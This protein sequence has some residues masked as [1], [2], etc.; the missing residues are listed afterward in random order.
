MS[1]EDSIYPRAAGV[2]PDF[3]MGDE[4]L[5]WCGWPS[6]FLMTRAMSRPGGVVDGSMLWE[7][8]PGS[9]PSGCCGP[10][11]DCGVLCP[12]ERGPPLIR[13]VGRLLNPPTPAAGCLVQLST[14]QPSVEPDSPGDS[15]RGRRLAMCPLYRK[16]T[17][18]FLSPRPGRLDSLW[19]LLET[20]KH[21]LLL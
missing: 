6:L 13:A 12:A 7:V 21:F 4:R 20:D 9:A 1:L 8:M 15:N 2:V 16:Q 3:R 10:E 5:I 18:E 19:T 14:V 17:G 11:L